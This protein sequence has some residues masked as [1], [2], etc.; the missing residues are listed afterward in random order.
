MEIKELDKVRGFAEK[1]RIV[2]LSFGYYL[3]QQLISGITEVLE[4]EAEENNL[5][6]GKSSDLLTIFIELSQNMM[7]YSKGMDPSRKKRDGLIVIGQSDESNYYVSSQN[8][9]SDTDKEKLEPILKEIAFMDRDQIKKR[10]RELRREG[11]NTH[12]K[13]GGFGMFE[14]AKRCSSI[15]FH[16]EKA[17]DQR[18]YFNI[19]AII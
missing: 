10:Y 4:K 17:N 18:Y 5:N 8:L 13:G 14:I 1:E 16:F 19:M 11:R 15:E 3:T 7:H 12:E 6:M 9:V 2:F